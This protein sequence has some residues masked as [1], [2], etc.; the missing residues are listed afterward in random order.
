M[1]SFL[2][3]EGVLEGG[4]RGCVRRRGVG[5]TLVRR[6]RGGGEALAERRGRT[7]V[8]DNAASRGAGW[9]WCRVVVVVDGWCR[10]PEPNAG[11]D[12]SRLLDTCTRRSKLPLSPDGRGS[13][14]VVLGSSTPLDSQVF[15]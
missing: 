13:V 9:W 7:G 10:K 15:I 3:V 1:Q 5:E 6:W 14:F 2:T 8:E 11:R 4:A 12:D